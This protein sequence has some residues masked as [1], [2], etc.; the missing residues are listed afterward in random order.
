[1]QAKNSSFSRRFT[2]PYLKRK[3][4]C[5]PAKDLFLNSY[6]TIAKTHVTLDKK[7]AIPLYA[8]HLHFLIN[9]C[10]C[11]LTNIRAYFTLVQGKFKKKFVVKNQVFRQNAKADVEQDF[12][13]LLSNSNFG[14]DCRNNAE[15]CFFNP[16]YGEIEE[17]SYA[18]KYQNVFDQSISDFVSSEILERQIEEEYLNEFASLDS[19][20]EYFDVRKNSL[21]I[22]K[23]KELDAVFS[24][25]KVRQKRHKKTLSK[26]LTKK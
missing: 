18:E 16:I 4:S 1:M 25:K 23:K 9:R 15:N 14:H 11:R 22:Q 13:K 8:E 26:T 21:L 20:D 7:Y 17:L 3:R 5:L 2:Y 10:G 24:M 19:Q 6:K 12:Y